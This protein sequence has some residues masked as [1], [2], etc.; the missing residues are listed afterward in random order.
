MQNRFLFFFLKKGGGTGNREVIYKN[1]KTIDEKEGGG[2]FFCVYICDLHLNL[3][4]V[5]YKKN[6]GG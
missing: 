2:L 3:N 5:R 4:H 6:D 1:R